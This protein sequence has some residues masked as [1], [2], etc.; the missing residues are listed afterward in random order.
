MDDF[1]NIIAAD[2]S[3]PIPQIKSL[4]PEIGFT[5]AD[6]L[7]LP[8]PIIILNGT[9]FMWD[10]GVPKEG[11]DGW[12]G[13]TEEKLKVFEVVSPRPE[14]LFIGTGL[15]GLFPPPHVKK[16]LNGLGI[17]V[18]ILDSKNAASTYNLLAEEGRRVACALYP[19][20]PFNAR[21]GTLRD[22]RRVH[23]P[24]MSRLVLRTSTRLARPTLACTCSAATSLAAPRFSLRAPSTLQP[25]PSR[26]QQLST[27]ATRFSNGGPAA[28]YDEQVKQGLIQNDEHQR[29]IVELLQKMYD[30]LEAYEPP[31][32]LPVPGP[33]PPPTFMQK[34]LGN[35]PPPLPTIPPIPENV[36]KGLYLYGSVGCGK[37]FLMDLF[38]ANLPKKFENSKRRVHF[39]AFMADVHLRG[40]RMKMTLTPDADWTVHAAQQLAKEARILCFD[41]FQVTDIVDAMI[42]KRLMQSLMAY[43]VV[44]V[45]TSNR[46][47]DELYRNGIQRDQFIPCIDLIK[48]RFKVKC[49][50]SDIDYRKQPRALSKVYFNP[51]NDATNSEINKLFDS[52]SGDQEPIPNRPL[53]VW[54][55]DIHVPLSTPHVAR[56]TFAELCGKPLSASDYLTITQQF[57]TVFLTDVPRLG[58]DTKDMARRLILFIDA[59]YEAKTKLFIQS[60]PPVN[61]IFS[62]EKP[63]SV[64]I[65]PYMRALMDEQGLN[66]DQVGASSIFTG[67]EEIFA[68]ARALEDDDSLAELEGGEM[69]FACRGL[70]SWVKEEP[71]S[72][73]DRHVDLKSI[74]ATQASYI[75]ALE[76]RV[77]KL[78]APVERTK[79]SDCQVAS[80]V[81]R[82]FHYQILEAANVQS[83]DD[84]WRRFPTY[85]SIRRM[86]IKGDLYQPF[87]PEARLRKAY[88]ATSHL[89]SFF[90]TLCLNVIEEC[91]CYYSP[92]GGAKKEPTY[93][94]FMA[95][96][97]DKVERFGWSREMKGEL[98]WRPSFYFQ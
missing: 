20:S 84:V 90:A 48:D 67:E 11:P 7:I 5:L 50:D 69:D 8:S 74:I 43:G 40:H 55:R 95:F 80:K 37:S 56:F 39:H 3:R 52:L 17:Q 53:T 78:E 89:E 1:V 73:Y 32:I 25:L 29:G 9:T 96:V 68:F 19:A 77:D 46:A 44:A 64:E 16:Y 63:K 27:S 86:A 30:E 98:A 35:A 92:Y 42:L 75:C 72:L 88:L 93:E 91:D 85:V 76:A 62:D 83:H 71:M 49:L 51:I 22:V 21:T 26:R 28:A 65:T 97:D 81:L 31:E 6:G 61:E 33:P 38:Y 23:R 82:I 12:D 54:G 34:L 10:V 66:M 45:M 4:S 14:I 13:F 59:A 60:D 41:E 47:P 70:G 24:A 94:E 36:P 87:T 79:R 18:D 15:R 57:E 2:A 58:L